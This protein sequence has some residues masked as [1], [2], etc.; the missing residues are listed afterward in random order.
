MSSLLR[1]TTAN[2]PSFDLVQMSPVMS[3]PSSVRVS[4][5]DFSSLWYRRSMLGPRSHSSPGSPTGT[6]VPS[7]ET[8]RASIVERSLPTEP[9]MDSSAGGTIATDVVSVMPRLWCAFRVS[10]RDV[11]G[12]RSEGRTPGR[13]ACGP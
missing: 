8:S 11:G 6:S 2:H 10:A 12:Q 5:V 1:S 4:R 13:R 7:G 9:G 3:H